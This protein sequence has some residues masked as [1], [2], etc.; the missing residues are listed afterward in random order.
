MRP[1]AETDTVFGD[2]LSLV[3]VAAIAA[4]LV[5][6]CVVD[7]EAIICKRQ[8]TI[9][10]RSA[11]DMVTL[12]VFDCLTS[13]AKNHAIDQRRHSKYERREAWRAA[14]VNLFWMKVISI[15]P[16]A[17]VL[18]APY[19]LCIPEKPRPVRVP[20]FSCVQ[21]EKTNAVLTPRVPMASNTA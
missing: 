19:S 17:I 3:V 15:C 20:H 14:P 12:C 13:V 1:S 21:V 8:R 18:S 7:G 6:S 2:R 4:V 16:A 10:R 5:R 11:G 9:H